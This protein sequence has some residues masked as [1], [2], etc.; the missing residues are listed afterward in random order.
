MLRSDTD[1]GLMYT[2][3]ARILLSDAHFAIMLRSDTSFGVTYT[4]SARI[5]LSDTFRY[6]VAL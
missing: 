4:R 6:I 5:L 1:R 3:S 2:C